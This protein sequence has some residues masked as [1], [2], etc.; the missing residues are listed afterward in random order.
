MP[1]IQPQQLVDAI[2]EAI[3]DS[4][5]IGVLISRT[6]THPRKIAVSGPMD[7]FELWVYAWTLTHG[8]RPQLRNEYRIQMT[9]VESP[10]PL[11]PNGPTVLIGYEPDLKMF[12]G[13]DLRLHRSFTT[14]SPSVQINITSLH[15]AIQ[16]GFSFHRKSNDEIA[17]G[18]RSDHFMAYVKNA[19]TLHKVATDRR[20]FNALEKASSLETVPVIDLNKLTKPRQRIVQ[21][22]SRI[23]RVASFRDQVLNAY[24]QRC[25][26]TRMQL[27]VVE[28]AHILP[29]SA[30]SSVDHVINGM[31]LSPT[32]H[33]A[34]DRG[35]IYLNTDYAMK[36]NAKE[37]HRLSELNLDCGLEEF[38]SV[39]GRIH[40]PQDRQQWPDKRLIAK[41]N[42]FRSIQ[43]S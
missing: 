24:G 36:L 28:A 32:Y 27:R 26:I 41:A 17:V 3:H 34:F 2:L 13:F 19:V 7:S 8:G 14:G 1:A 9:S 5:E 10:L 30:P 21:E 4:G 12:A 38:A 29:L 16:N 25:A 18:I 20:V 11:N 23:A 43:D 35:L 40:L 22:I 42:K 33:R 15:K 39:L 37:T 6:R 31:A